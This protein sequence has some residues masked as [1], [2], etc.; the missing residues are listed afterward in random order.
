MTGTH[1]ASHHLAMPLPANSPPQPPGGL[2]SWAYSTVKLGPPPAPGQAVSIVS[3]LS[4]GRSSAEPSQRPHPE[5]P[6]TTPART[7]EGV[8]QLVP[9]CGV[10]VTLAGSRA[11]LGLRS[12]SAEL[13]GCLQGDQ[14][15]EDGNTKK[16]LGRTK[17]NPRPGEGQTPIPQTPR[18]QCSR[19]LRWGRTAEKGA[20]PRQEAESQ[21]PVTEV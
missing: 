10:H 7:W 14:L 4:G 16:A 17:Q 6:L 9:R 19:G 3:R 2:L 12:R 15:G 20:G 1:E 5:G 18:A 13:E 21:K 11:T 8:T